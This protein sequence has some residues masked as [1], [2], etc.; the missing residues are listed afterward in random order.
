M[1]LGEITLAECDELR[2]LALAM[3]SENDP[4]SPRQLSRSLEF[5]ESTLPSK[6]S[7]EQAGQM[8]TAVYIRIFGGYTKEAIA[9]LVERACKECDWFPTP[10]QCL[11]ILADYTPQPSIKQQALH[12]CEKFSQAM[13]DQ[14]IADMRDGPI[15]Q[16]QIDNAPERWKRIC[17]ETGLLRREGDGY[18][19]RVK[20]WEL[21]R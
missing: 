3:P 19:Q 9:Y 20:I 7:D 17:V 16:S 2:T 10:K 4:V 11:E 14:F 5:M 1:S 6:N 15:T 12:R 21:Y 13:F 18:V 8:R